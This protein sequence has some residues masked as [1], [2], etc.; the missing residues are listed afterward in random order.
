MMVFTQNSSITLSSAL[1]HHF[2]TKSHRALETNYSK[3]KTCNA[4]TVV[5]MRTKHLA[6]KHNHSSRS[7]NMSV[8]MEIGRD[9]VIHC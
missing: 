2:F 5:L 4:I 6:V 9:F 8:C 1:P 7:L 3:A